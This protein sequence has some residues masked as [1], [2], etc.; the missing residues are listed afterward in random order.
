[1]HVRGETK[2]GER[3]NFSI[4]HIGGATVMAGI[5]IA[6]SLF[7]TNPPL[8]SRGFVTKLTRFGRK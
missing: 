4:P 6:V 7:G 1:M 2:Y 8:S 5:A 3:Y